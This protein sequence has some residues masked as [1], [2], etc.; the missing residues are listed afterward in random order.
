MVDLDQAYKSKGFEETVGPFGILAIG[1]TSRISLASCS[2]VGSSLENGMKAC[3]SNASSLQ[4]FVL[5]QKI[6]IRMVILTAMKGSVMLKL[7]R[8]SMSSAKALP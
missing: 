1:I 4:S 6:A 8:E 3:I 2:S 5:V 7:M